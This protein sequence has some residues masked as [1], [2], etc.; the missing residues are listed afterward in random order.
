MSLATR[1]KGRGRTVKVAT[2]LE[3]RLRA[4]H[5]L[6]VDSPNTENISGTVST[7]SHFGAYSYFSLVI[8]GITENPRSLYRVAKSRRG[9]ELECS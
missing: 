2:I 1:Q 4:S 8:K 5:P 6:P 7:L 3:Q 9:S